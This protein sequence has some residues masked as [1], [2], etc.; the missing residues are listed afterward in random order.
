MLEH[1]YDPR[2]EYAGQQYMQDPVNF[3]VSDVDE[4]IERIKEKLDEMFP[5]RH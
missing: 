1:Y 2:Y 5:S 3:E 4:A